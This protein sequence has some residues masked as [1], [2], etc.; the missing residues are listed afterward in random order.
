MI[1]SDFRRPA[2][3][4][5]L[6][7]H[8]TP[9]FPVSGHADDHQRPLTD[10]G[11]QQAQTLIP[12]LAAPAPQAVYSSPYRRAVQTVE[13]TARLLGLTVTP[14]AA[15]REWDSGLIPCDD[16]AQHYAASW[17][18]PDLIRPGGESLRQLGRRAVAAL[19]NI[20]AAHP[21]SAVLVGSHGTFIARALIGYG[22]AFDH[23]SWMAM[24]MPA[25]YRLR[26]SGGDAVP[27]VAGPH[28]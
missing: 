5:I 16:W 20:L 9:V 10:E 24:P 18:Q 3:E 23:E 22:I 12:G 7:R 19:D 27:S 8:A 4:L 6:V 11:H 26:F 21:G 28:C 14:V 17:S 25:V 1:S 15:L 2:G 13:P